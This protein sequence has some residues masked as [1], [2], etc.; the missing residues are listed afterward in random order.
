[1][2]TVYKHTCPNGKVY[3]GITSQKLENRWRKGKGYCKNTLFH[4]A[5]EK[6]GWDNL[7]H[8]T[9]FEN[10]T[11]EEA[12]QKEIELISS[13]KSN[14]RECGYNVANGG[15]CVGMFSE[16]TKEKLRKANIG[17][18][19]SEETKRKI[20][21][22]LKGEKCYLFGK[23]LSEETKEKLSK[24]HLGKKLSEATRERMRERFKRES[25]PMLGR[26]GADNPVA[27]AVLCVET[28]IVYPSITMASEQN[29][30]DA[31]SITNVCKGRRKTAGGF[32]WQYVI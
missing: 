15:Q 16:E 7:K 29:K 22:A 2:Y 10:L 3:I 27:K 9:L 5:I 31:A 32:H 23:H 6:Y 11:K 17:K 20:S 25:H 28:N 30:V 18:K 24:A 14:E 19:Q 1:M 8:E 26:K 13:H 4:R 21:E 12:E